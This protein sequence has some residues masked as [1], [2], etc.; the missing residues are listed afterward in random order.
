MVFPLG[1]R[2]RAPD[3][4]LGHAVAASILEPGAA[5]DRLTEGIYL[6]SRRDDPLGRI[7]QAFDAVLKAS[8]AEAK[9]RKARKDAPAG[10]DEDAAISRL[11]GENVLSAEEI[12]LLHDAREAI[13][14][15][16]IVDSFAA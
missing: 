1:R 8:D 15:A 2:R 13:R 12:S 6:N 9:L 4:R 11:Q 5:R 7:E 16:I 14:Q 10:E 3:D